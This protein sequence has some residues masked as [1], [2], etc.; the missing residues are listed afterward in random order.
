[1]IKYWV[2]PKNKFVEW[3]P[4][5]VSTDYLK[6]CTA[7][8]LTKTFK[9]DTFMN[10]QENIWTWFEGG[11]LILASEANEV[12]S[13]TVICRNVN[14]NRNIYGNDDV[15]DIQLDLISLNKILLNGVL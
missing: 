9:G 15:N 11:Q 10:I 5:N 1:M 2:S 3:T 13:S 14:V 6:T 8:M 12:T 4:K 7:R